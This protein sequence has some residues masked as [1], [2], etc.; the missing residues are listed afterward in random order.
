MFL[1]LA[2]FRYSQPTRPEQYL[3]RVGV[4]KEWPYKLLSNLR[5]IFY[6]LLWIFL[7][8]S[9]ILKCVLMPLDFRLEPSFQS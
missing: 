2:V 7:I 6:K 5:Q 9:S 8:G 1:C 3:F 4:N